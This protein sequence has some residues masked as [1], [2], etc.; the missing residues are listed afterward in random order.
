M[1]KIEKEC[2]KNLGYKII[3]LEKNNNVYEEIS[4]HVD[5]FCTKIN[6]ILVVE[7][8]FFDKISYILK[9]KRVL[10]RKFKMWLFLSRRYKI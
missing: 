2:I 9:D 5:I 1:R 4:S 7:K 8:T 10:K 3:E 6:D